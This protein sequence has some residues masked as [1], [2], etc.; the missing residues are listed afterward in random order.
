MDE[1]YFQGDLMFKKVHV[2]PS[3]L[4]NV[5]D[6]K[7]KIVLAVGEKTGHAHVVEADQHIRQG[8][9][10]GAQVIVVGKNGATILHQ[11]ND[12]PEERHNP[13]VL[14]EGV[15]EVTQQRRWVHEERPKAVI[16]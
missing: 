5:T 1:Q 16:D 4:Q 3:V 15:Y 11:G 12:A 9:F 10:G 6:Q 7:Y 2:N 8:L 13:L 14:P